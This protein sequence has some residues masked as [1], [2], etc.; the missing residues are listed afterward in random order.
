MS[1]QK[2]NFRILSLKIIEIVKSIFN[3]S[4]AGDM[5]EYQPTI[6]LSNYLERN[7]NNISDLIF[8]QKSGTQL[9]FKV[10]NIDDEWVMYFLAYPKGFAIQVNKDPMDPDERKYNNIT[11]SFDTNKQLYFY[12]IKTS[13]YG[14]RISGK[15]FNKLMNDLAYCMKIKKFY[16]SDSAGIK[17]HLNK[18]IEIE[19]FSIMRVI[20][21]KSTFYATDFKGD[22]KEPKIAKDEINTINRIVS[23]D[24]KK[25]IRDYLESL[26]NTDIKESPE[27]TEKCN[28][29]NK[30]IENV[31]NE[32]S[33]KYYVPEILKFI[34]TPYQSDTVQHGGRR[35]SKVTYKKQNK[36]KT[37]K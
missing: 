17:C 18:S 29:I 20:A 16:I 36:R 24:D 4:P 22:F 12:G 10:G 5:D 28:R 1:N 33:K 32:L 8:I 3:Q 37:K 34:A 11:L 14:P 31:L 35:K 9:Y 19:H 25:L 23:D 15:E 27:N 2:N 30:I 26:K 13:G 6:F 21:G 7:L